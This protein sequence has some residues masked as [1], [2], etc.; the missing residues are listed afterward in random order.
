MKFRHVLLAVSLG[1]VGSTS[2]PTSARMRYAPGKRVGGSA[3]AIAPEKSTQVC[4]NVFPA[5]KPDKSE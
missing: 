4:V 5:H 3:L 2:A 1:A